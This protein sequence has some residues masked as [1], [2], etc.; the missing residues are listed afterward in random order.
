[1]FWKEW[2]IQDGLIHVSY[3]IHYFYIFMS[4][5]G[6]LSKSHVLTSLGCIK[7]GFLEGQF[8]PLCPLCV[9][10]AKMIW[11]LVSFFSFFFYFAM[12]PP[13]TGPPSKHQWIFTSVPHDLKNTYLTSTFWGQVGKQEPVPFVCPVQPGHRPVVPWPRSLM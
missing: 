3:S 12:K 11:W 10:N 13:P 2:V 7:E 5:T 4:E 8:I 6:K 1:M 9:L